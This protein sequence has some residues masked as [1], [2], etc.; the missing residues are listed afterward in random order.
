MARASSARAAVT[1][2][3]FRYAARRRVEVAAK[4]RA[5]RRLGLGR[6]RV[7][8]EIRGRDRVGLL[9]DLVA[10]H[11]EAGDGPREGERHEEPEEA[12]DRPFDGSRP[13]VRPGGILPRPAHAEATAPLQEREHPEKE[14]EGEE[15]AEQLVAHEWGVPLAD[16]GAVASPGARGASP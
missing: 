14:A 6:Q 16:R 8:P 9:D 15:Q 7:D 11:V 1:S 10:A 4:E 13:F 12:E 5:Q 3:S 2:G